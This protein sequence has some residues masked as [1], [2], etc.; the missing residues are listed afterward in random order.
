MT[1]K[2]LIAAFMLMLPPL[3]GHAHSPSIG[4]NG[5]PQTDAGTY[6][7]ELV[8][9]GTELQVYLRD[10][11]DK[12]VSTQ[13]F[14]G[15]AIFVMGGKTER[16]TLAPSGDNVL[17]GTA[18]VTLPATPKGAVQITPPSGPTVQARFN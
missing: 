15:V 2:T 4:H 8:V 3:A 9:K 12:P 6:H 5:G 11:S 16:I 13:G 17:K 14:K 18:T 10:H 7:A 1:I